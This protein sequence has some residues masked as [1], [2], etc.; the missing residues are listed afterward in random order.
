[1]P[2]T[3]DPHMK[4]KNSSV[5]PATTSSTTTAPGNDPSVNDPSVGATTTT[6]LPTVLAST[7]V[8]PGVIIP[9]VSPEFTPVNPLDYMGAHPKRGQLSAL[10]GAIA[11]LDSNGPAYAAALGPLAPS[12]PK[13]VVELTNAGQW[14]ALRK[15]VDA[16]SIYVRSNEAICWKTALGDLE[17]L[18]VMFRLLQKQ[19]LSLATEFPELTKLLDVPKMVAARA[20]ATKARKSK[21]KQK[22]ATPPTPAATSAPAANPSSTDEQLPAPNPHTPLATAVTIA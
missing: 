4:T 5:L 6:T 7:S 12:A 20:S 1:M 9:S 8:P 18:N 15:R 17:Q 22:A 10:S 19:N 3:T 11:E 21:A 2:I 14:T 13:L 16:F